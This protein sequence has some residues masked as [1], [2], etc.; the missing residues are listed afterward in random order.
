MT[1]LQ[2]HLLQFLVRKRCQIIWVPAL[3]TPAFGI[4]LPLE[5]L[6]GFA[7]EEIGGI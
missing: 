3:N 6:E 4:P 1:E 7:E 2:L 5:C